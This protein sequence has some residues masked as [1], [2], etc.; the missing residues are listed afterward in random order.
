MEEGEVRHLSGY[1]GILPD[2][3]SDRSLEWETSNK[4]V[5][6]VDEKGVVSAV[7]DG[8]AV[9][10]VRASDSKLTTVL[11]EDG[12]PY[13]A[14]SPAE[15]KLEITVG[16]GETPVY[17]WTGS[18]ALR[19]YGTEEEPVLY[20]R[21]ELSEGQVLKTSVERVVDPVVL[22]L[23]DGDGR[24]VDAAVLTEEAADRSRRVNLFAE[25]ADGLRLGVY[26]I[27]PDGRFRR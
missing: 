25:R 15:V 1:L 10:T 6:T 5:V 20:T 27:R 2:N 18:A 11:A 23:Y 9:V 17:L 8:K 21:A 19:N 22:V 16:T 14:L 13:E 24:L 26:A 3:A 7:S 4:D 12:T